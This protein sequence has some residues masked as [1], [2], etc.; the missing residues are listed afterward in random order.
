VVAAA[1]L[2]CLGLFFWGH[3][4]AGLAGWEDLLLIVI[5]LIL[6]LLEAFVIPGF[7]IAG[8]LGGL[9]LVGGLVLAMT[10]RDFGDEGF[11]AEVGDVLTTLLVTLGAT[12]VVIVIVTVALPR[13][14]P[15]IA[16]PAR[17]VQR[18]TLSA[19]V[20]Q[21]GNNPSR[22]GFFTRLL[23]GAETV[24]RDTSGHTAITRDANGAPDA[25]RDRVN[26]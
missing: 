5:G 21:G 13:L 20:A 23:G 14:V 16:R 6:I 17:G 22:P 15:S 25:P 7:G 11:G 24:G 18:L 9:A 26:R 2:G 19:T 8:I 10:R 1:G 4:L 3:H 12:V